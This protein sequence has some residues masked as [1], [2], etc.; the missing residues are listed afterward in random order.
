MTVTMNDSPLKTIEEMISF[1]NAS[2]SV[3]FEGQR[4][5]TILF[6]TRQQEDYMTPYEKLRSLTNSASYL[7]PGI[8][9]HDLD[10]IESR[11]D[12]NQLADEV[13]DKR[14]QLFNKI[15]PAYSS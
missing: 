11:K 1:L 13:Q 12:D 3:S 15:L 10:K 5:C 7:R 2:G 6:Y 4:K 9:F 8:T 14:Y